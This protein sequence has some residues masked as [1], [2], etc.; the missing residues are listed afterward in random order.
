MPH[1]PKKKILTK[2]L[3]MILEIPHKTP[4]NKTRNHKDRWR[5]TRYSKSYKQRRDGSRLCKNREV[6]GPNKENYEMK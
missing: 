1:P 5:S 3:A 2:S 6:L 4:R